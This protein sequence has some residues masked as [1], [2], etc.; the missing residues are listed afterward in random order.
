MYKIFWT[1]FPT[2]D[3]HILAF[4]NENKKHLI[5]KNQN[6]INTKRQFNIF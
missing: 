4:L 5:K 2:I 3:F 1:Q 6:L